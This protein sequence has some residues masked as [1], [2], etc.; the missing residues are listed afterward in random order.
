MFVQFSDATQSTIIATFAS[1]QNAAAYPN[2]GT[3][4]AS[5]A[6][7]AT[8]YATLP[9]SFQAALTPPTSPASPPLAQ[10]AAAALAAGITIASASTPA[11]NGTYAID[12]ASQMKIMATSQYISV[13][14]NF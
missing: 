12:P 7:W 1:P 8:F 5:D 9:A 10:Q 13:N 6:R 3:V 14:G 11:L 4:A 2:Q